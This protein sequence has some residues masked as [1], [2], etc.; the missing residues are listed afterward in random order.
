MLDVYDLKEGH[1][2]YAF[3]EKMVTDP[4]VSHVLV[5]CDK[6]YEEKANA[7]N[8]GVGTESQIISKEV[9]Q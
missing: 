5:I 1:D 7:R 9:Y 2:K 4:E 8:A 3:L 6:A